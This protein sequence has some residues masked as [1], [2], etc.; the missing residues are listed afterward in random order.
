MTVEQLQAVFLNNAREWLEPMREMAAE[1]ET[2]RGL[3]KRNTGAISVAAAVYLRAMTAYFEPKVAIEIGTFI[4]VSTRAIAAKHV[5]TCDK[6]NGCLPSTRRIT[7][8][9]FTGSTRM[10]SMLARQRRTADFFFFDGRIRDNDIDLLQQLST[11]R[12][13]YA[14]DDFDGEEKG[15]VNVNLLTARWP[16]I[17][18]RYHLMRPPAAVP[19]VEG[20]TTIAALIPERWL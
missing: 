17:S 10:L 11:D 15:V 2:L 20:Q 19:G 3:A 7:C 16:A 12:T 18:R 9:P 14:F 6:S 4:G 13:V 1:A 8:H 5:Y